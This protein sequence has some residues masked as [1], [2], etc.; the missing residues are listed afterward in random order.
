MNKFNYL[1]FTIIFVTSCTNRE[2]IKNA[3]A[4][5]NKAK[6]LASEFYENLSMMDTVKINNRLTK[7]LNIDEFNKTIKDKINVSGSIN[8]ADVINVETMDENINGKYVKTIYDLQVIVKYDN[9][10]NIETLGFE[11]D[12]T[13]NISIY[14][15]Y[16][17]LKD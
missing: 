2:A 13:G 9:H 1:I 15:Y 11:K 16:S 5:I 14:S 6:N 3:P 4:D 8:N 7:D 17:K 12:S 10:T